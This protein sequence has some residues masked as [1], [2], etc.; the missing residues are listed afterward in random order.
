MVLAFSWDARPL[1]VQFGKFCSRSLFIAAGRGR[2]FAGVHR[3]QR[4]QSPNSFTSAGSTP[5]CC[6]VGALAVSS[7]TLAS[8]GFGIVGFGFIPLCPS[9][10]WARY[11][12]VFCWISQPSFGIGLRCYGVSWNHEKGGGIFDSDQLDELKHSILQEPI[13]LLDFL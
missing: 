4:R 2:R 5:R 3:I 9:R 1:A 12:L 8:I 7:R 6:A 11:L 10:L 13:P